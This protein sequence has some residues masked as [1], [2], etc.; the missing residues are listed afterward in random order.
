MSDR[1]MVTSGLSKAYGIPGVRIGWIVGPARLVAECWSQHDYITIG[2][3][4][5]SRPHRA[6]RGGGRQSRAMLRAHRRSPEEEPADCARLGVV[7]RGTP[8][9]D[10]TGAAPSG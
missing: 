5:F 7:I 2:P 10:R 1:V 6:G 3:N 9:V 4:K 8:H